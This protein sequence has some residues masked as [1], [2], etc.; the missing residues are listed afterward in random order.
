MSGTRPGMCNEGL[1]LS[2]I[3]NPPLKQHAQTTILKIT[4]SNTYMISKKDKFS[5][6]EIYFVVS[7]CQRNRQN[8]QQIVVNKT[9]CCDDCCVQRWSV[10]RKKVTKIELQSVMKQGRIRLLKT[11]ERNEIVAFK[12]NLPPPKKYILKRSEEDTLSKC[13]KTTETMWRG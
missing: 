11:K 13:S 7:P 1:P 8:T 6:Y 10:T 12:K 5:Q 3:Q 4:N 2:H 9:G